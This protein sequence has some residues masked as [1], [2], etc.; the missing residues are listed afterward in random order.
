MYVRGEKVVDL[1]G[2]QRCSASDQPWTEN[3]LALVFSVTKGM[4]AAAMAVAHSRGLFE[5]DRPVAKY[6]PEFAQ[7]SKSTIPVR[8]LLSHTAG[9]TVHGFDGYAADA[10]C[11]TVPCDCVG[12]GAQYRAVVFD[13]FF[14]NLNTVYGNVC[15]GT[16]DGIASAMPATARP[17]PSAPASSSSGRSASR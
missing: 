7:A 8:M 13:R 2:G 15:A 3:T 16:A 4:A 17:A 9:L 14:S 10:A 12:E 6:W 5:L 11:P 1:W